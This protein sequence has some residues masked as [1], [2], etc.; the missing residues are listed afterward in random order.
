MYAGKRHTNLKGGDDLDSYIGKRAQ[1]GLKLPRGFQ[2]VNS[3][4]T[5][6]ERDRVPETVN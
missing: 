5:W 6:S 2:N 3:I 4:R 1:R